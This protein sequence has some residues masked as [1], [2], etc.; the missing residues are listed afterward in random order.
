M[1]MINSSILF[2]RTTGDTITSELDT[3][4]GT[5]NTAN[6]KLFEGINFNLYYFQIYKADELVVDY[7]PYRMYDEVG[8]YDNISDSF[9]TLHKDT[10]NEGVLTSIIEP[11][12]SSMPE[13]IYDEIK[14]D[15]DD[16]WKAYKR[17]STL[18]SDNSV[19]TGR[20]EYTP[21]ENEQVYVLDNQ[22]FPEILTVQNQGLEETEP[23]NNVSYDTMPI[24]MD[25]QYGSND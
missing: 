14:K 4:S 9:L 21:L 23:A 5:T 10:N 17:V 2:T 25:I 19:N 13:K 8:L 11:T 12:Y 20:G 1:E 16:V 18:R 24:I 15:T 22:D 6:I 3:T 7:I